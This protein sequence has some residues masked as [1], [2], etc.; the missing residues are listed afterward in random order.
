MTAAD[1]AGL[2]ASQRRALEA[3]Y[4]AAGK[5][6][7]EEAGDRLL[8]TRA[9]I[10]LAEANAFEAL[11]LTGRAR[12][13]GRPPRAKQ[14]PRAPAAKPDREATTPKPRRS[15]APAPAKPR[16]VTHKDIAGEQEAAL[17]RAYQAGDQ[18]AGAT[19]LEAH[20]PVI[21]FYSMR[22]RNRGLD[23]EELL[24]EGRIGFLKAVE[25]FDPGHGA[26]LS[27]YAM[28]WIRAAV[29]H[30]V[31]DTGTTVRVPAGAREKIAHGR[32][33]GIDT[34]EGLVKAGIMQNE[35]RAT[36]AMMAMGRPISL[37]A[38][39]WTDSEDPLVDTIAADVQGPEDAYEE[40]ERLQRAKE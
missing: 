38:P 15:V 25:R 9:A 17:I 37:D 6:S 7:Y 29:Q 2:T 14:Q 13:L 30:A 26:K 27:T 3:R 5:L 35:A 28:H 24:Q 16:R 10:H 33:R 22:Q 34:A 18:K 31:R 12:K 19:L 8:V 4:L 40:A 1:L 39:A 23:D 32:A 36:A 20:S 21:S 11:G